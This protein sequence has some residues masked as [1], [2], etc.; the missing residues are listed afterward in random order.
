[1]DLTEVRS[2]P[3]FG[4]EVFYD[5]ED[6]NYLVLETGEEDGNVQMTGGEM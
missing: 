3:F 4:D 2:N 5:L 1:M 6:R